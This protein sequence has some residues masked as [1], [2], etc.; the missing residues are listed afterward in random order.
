MNNYTEYMKS[1]GNQL[2]L[3]QV[4]QERTADARRD[5]AMSLLANNVNMNDKVQA[6]EVKLNTQKAFPKGTGKDADP[7]EKKAV[8]AIRQVVSTYR[9]G[10]E[11]SIFPED[12]NT[13]SEWRKEVYGENKAKAKIDQIKRW[14]DNNQITTQEIQELLNTYKAIID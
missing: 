11:Q 1:L 13:Y 8:Q 14:I 9:K 12:Y 2:T 5:L 6:A 7:E 10:C 3:Q 4:A